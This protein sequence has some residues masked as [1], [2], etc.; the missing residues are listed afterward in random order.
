MSLI[1]YHHFPVKSANIIA[2]GYIWI[3][4]ELASLSKDGSS[5]GENIF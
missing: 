2:K 4:R 1:Y 3:I 5:S